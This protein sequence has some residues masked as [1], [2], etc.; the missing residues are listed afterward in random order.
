VSGGTWHPAGCRCSGC[1]P[2]TASQ[3]PRSPRPVYAYKPR[4]HAY[5]CRCSRCTQVRARNK[6]NAGII[7]PGLV[8]IFVVA[9]VGFWPAMVWHGEGGPTGT[10]WEWNVDSTVGCC[11]WWG[12]WVLGL[13]VAF[14]SASAG[15]RRAIRAED[16]ASAARVAAAQAVAAA[17]PLEAATAPCKHPNAVPVDNDM[18]GRLAWWCPDCETQLS[19]G[20]ICQHPNAVPSVSQWEPGVIFGYYCPDCET[21]LGPG[22]R[23][24]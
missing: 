18:L 12:I 13:T 24:S 7:G 4:S 15:R 17:R 6:G 23:A 2:R 8:V 9:L 10:A 11:I 3:P 19:P 20:D 16:R 22:F 14:V 1:R 21:R 5:N